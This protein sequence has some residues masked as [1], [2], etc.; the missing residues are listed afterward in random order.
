MRHLPLV[1]IFNGLFGYAYY[2]EPATLPTIKPPTAGDST[3]NGNATPDATPITIY[4]TSY[5]AHTALGKGTSI[6]RSGNFA[7]AVSPKLINGHRLM[8]VDNKGRSSQIVV[9]SPPSSAVAGPAK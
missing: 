7:V 8:A 3:V 2:A 4:D 9:V 6:D 5:P 1:I